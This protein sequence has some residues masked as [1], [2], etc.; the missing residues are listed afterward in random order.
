MKYMPL[1]IPDLVLMTPKVF[2]DPRGFFME[3]FRADGF[4]KNVGNYSFVQDNCSRSSFGIL[5]GLHY[6]LCHPQGK[7]VQVTWGTVFD[8]AVDLRRASV[9]FGQWAGVELCADDHQ[10]LWVPP[11]FAHGFYVL[12]PE[13]EFEYKCTNYYDPDSECCIQWDDPVLDIDWPLS[14][15]VQPLLSSKDQQGISF[16]TAAVYP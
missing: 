3:T 6:Q 7:L 16:E 9:T 4:E 8:V 1:E 14:P 2:K 10:L 15:G 11:G 12:S 5:R 13:A